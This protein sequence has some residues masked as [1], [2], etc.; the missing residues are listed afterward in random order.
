MMEYPTFRKDKLTVFS[1]I[2]SAKTNYLATEVWDN[3]AWKE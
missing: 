3:K 2:M 1:S